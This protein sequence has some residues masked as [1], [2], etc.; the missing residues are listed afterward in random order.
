M[1][2]MR[3]MPPSLSQ[4][5]L[6]SL[7]LLLP[8]HSSE[9]LSQSDQP[10]QV[11]WDEEHDKH[12]LLCD[13]NRDGDSYRSPWSSKYKPDLEDG[14]QPSPELRALEKEANEVFSIYRDQYYEGGISS[15]Y[16]W[17][18]EDGKGFAACV[19]IKKD[20]SDSGDGRRGLLQEGSWD[21]IHVIEVKE[22]QDRQ[23]GDYCLTSTV[24]LALTTADQASGPFSLSGSITRQMESNL[25]LAPG[26][27]CNMG[28]LIEEMESKLRNGLDQVYFGKTKEVVFTL[29]EPMGVMSS[30]SHA[31]QSLQRRIA[32]D[33]TRSRT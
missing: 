3:R 14:V 5:A 15:V 6:D 2:L 20:G 32:S 19:L 25:S 33:F 23:Y 1:D 12:Y 8:A 28:R 30:T 18:P 10:L 13:Y 31:G 22:D 29:R 7:L 16:V 11:A 17:E 4:Q 9:L 21:A 24:M 26:H 27:L